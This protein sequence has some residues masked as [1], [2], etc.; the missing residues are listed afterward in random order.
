MESLPTKHSTPSEGQVTRPACCDVRIAPAAAE[1]SSAVTADVT[2]SL[3]GGFD[4]APSRLPSDSLCE[5]DA[6]WRGATIY[7]IYP[8]S[9]KDGNGDG[10]GDLRGIIE[11]L[12]Y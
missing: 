9:F 12:D 3:Y 10:V 8:R 6:W 4:R 2:T 7:Q 5:A 1:T 11:K